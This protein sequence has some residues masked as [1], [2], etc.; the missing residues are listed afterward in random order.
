MS[1]E[2]LSIPRDVFDETVRV[3]GE[4]VE[5]IRATGEEITRELADFSRIERRLI[6]SGAGHEAIEKYREVV[7][8]AQRVQV[9]AVRIK[10]A[11]QTG[12]REIRNCD[13]ELTPVCSGSQASMR[14]FKASQEYS[15]R[16]GEALRKKR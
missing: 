13:R 14:A 11:A 12:Y 7:A 5:T 8:F 9:A 15:E 6:E 1:Q 10:A 4:S 16:A 3:L 2:C